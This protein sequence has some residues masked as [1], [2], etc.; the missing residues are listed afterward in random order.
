MQIFCYCNVLKLISI[1]GVKKYFHPSFDSILLQNEEKRINTLVENNYKKGLDLQMVII[2]ESVQGWGL[3]QVFQDDIL[4][5]EENSIIDQ[6]DTLQGEENSIIECVQQNWLG[7]PL[8][9]FVQAKRLS[10]EV[11]QDENRRNQW[12]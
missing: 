9:T 7:M 8:L 12:S 1:I 2:S 6:D 3:W 10:G 5:G 4:Q 11:R